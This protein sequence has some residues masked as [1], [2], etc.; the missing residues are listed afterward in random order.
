MRIDMVDLM[1]NIDIEQNVYI[2]GVLQIQTH[3]P[4]HDS[5]RIE[6][7]LT[8]EE[9]GLIMNKHM[10]KEQMAEKKLIEHF[11]VD[12]QK[13]D[14]F[15]IEK[16]QRELAIETLKGAVTDL[17]IFVSNSGGGKSEPN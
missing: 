14:K 5:A 6:I 11:E 8:G 2:D 15:E 16:Y 12:V 4:P 17:A 3:K 9:V 1:P 13:I 10:T 7:V